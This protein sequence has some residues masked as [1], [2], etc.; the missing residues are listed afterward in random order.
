MLCVVSGST[1]L[2]VSTIIQYWTPYYLKKVLYVEESAVDIAFIVTCVTSPTLGILFGGFIIQKFGG[3]ESK[4]CLNICCIFG[5]FCLVIAIPIT[6]FDTIG[7]FATFLWIFLFFGGAIIPNIIGI[8]L[9]TLPNELRGSANS[10]TNFFNNIIGFILAPILYGFIS[11]RTKSSPRFAYG[12]SVIYS[13][14]PLFFMC[15]A[16]YY[17]RKDFFNIKNTIKENI[18]QE[19]DVSKIEKLGIILDKENQIL[20]Q[21]IDSEDVEEVNISQVKIEVS[22]IIFYKLLFLDGG[23]RW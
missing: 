20:N 7:G 14:V 21:Q 12:F 2:F 22:F 6:Q 9:S 11:E 5:I 15:L 13:V 3:Y 8:S 16:N 1:L 23:P 4:N 17:R 19:N 10:S 18:K